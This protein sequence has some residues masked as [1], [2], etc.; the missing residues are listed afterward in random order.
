MDLL[1]APL[2]DDARH[3]WEK[4]RCAFFLSVLER[5]GLR[6]RSLRVLDVGSGDGW[7]ARKLLAACPGSEITCW[8]VNYPFAERDADG[9]RYRRERPEGHVDLLLMMDV[10]EHVE[11]DRSFLTE[12]VQQTLAPHSILLFSVPAWQA[13][14]SEHD[15]ALKHFRRYSPQQATAVLEGAGLRLRE[16]GG[17]FHSLLVPRLLSVGIERIGRG[18]PVEANEAA[19]WNAPGW[20]TAAVDGALAID[21]KL[22]Q[23]A[24]RRG[25]SIPGLS[26]WALASPR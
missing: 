8:D 10:L 7:F 13:M 12:L 5:H 21:G 16:K 15:R 26:F 24:S 11:D 18:K 14:F 22:S 3:P 2:P 4:A 25:L 9:I 20:V 23:L 6:G 1:D 17:L 19:A